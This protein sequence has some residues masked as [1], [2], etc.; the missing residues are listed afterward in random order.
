MNL[1]LRFLWMMAAA[2]LGARTVSGRRDMA[3]ENHIFFR[4]M[5]WDLDLNMHMTNSR[6]S[7][8]M[9]L[10]RVDFMIRNGAWARLRAAGLGP[11]VASL[12]I[13]FRRP[14]R[15]FQRFDVTARIVSWDDR[16]IYLEQKILVGTE[17]ASIA[18]MK[19]TF[20]GKEGRLPVEKLLAIMG[21][22]GEKPPF[23]DALAKKD[24]L[25]AALKV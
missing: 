14:I 21:Y 20:I 15:V 4:C 8:F 7:S 5:P 13:R 3:G 6:Y 17:V 9:D 19:V 11:V 10:S 16:W 23:T 24:A 22:A 2:Y 1:I 18:L 25:D 12:T